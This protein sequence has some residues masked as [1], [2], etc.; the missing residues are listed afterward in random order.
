MPTLYVEGVAEEVYDAL[1]N[2][3]KE[4][5]TSISAEVLQLLSQFVPTQAELEQRQQLLNLSR[6]LTSRASATE[7]NSSSEE[8]LREDRSR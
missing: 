3:A 2:R 1:R 5:R 8:L 4:N 7:G 6:Q